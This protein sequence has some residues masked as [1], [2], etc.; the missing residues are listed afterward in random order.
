MP[1]ASAPPPSPGSRGGPLAER[2]D[3]VRRAIETVGHLVDTSR[4]LRLWAEAVEAPRWSAEV[5]LHG[6][7]LPGNVLVHEGRLSAVIDWG[8]LTTGDPAAD[9]VAA[10]HLFD[11]PQRHRFLGA[12]YDAA[13][14]RARGH[15]ISQAVIALPCYE[16]TN[17]G[18]VAQSLRVD[19]SR[20]T[21][22]W[23]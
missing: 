20:L 22:H 1:T 5:W 16:H 18:I 21:G 17:P 8:L 23:R 7:L 14:R 12:A 15:T 6:D 11:A 19:R 9:L 13:V 2:D 10:W 3:D 4:T